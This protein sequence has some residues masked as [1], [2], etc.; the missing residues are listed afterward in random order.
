MRGRQSKNCKQIKIN[1]Q[2][3]LKI[4][5]RPMR[6]HLVSMVNHSGSTLNSWNSWSN[7]LW[8]RYFNDSYL[9]MYYN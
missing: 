1:K 7:T 2:I 8:T 5:D 9:P 3:Y 6:Y 4:N